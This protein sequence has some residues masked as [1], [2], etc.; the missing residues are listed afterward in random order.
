MCSLVR[1][2]AAPNGPRHVCRKQKITPA[3]ASRKNQQYSSLGI[4]FSSENNVRSV[5]FPLS[6]ALAASDDVSPYVCGAAL[7][8]GLLFPGET[9]RGYMDVDTDLCYEGI[10][11]SV[12][13]ML[14]ESTSRG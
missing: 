11:F 13:T 2:Q 14:S 10:V 12:V 5:S 7:A 3:C 1:S 4:F 8:D 9:W 6:Q